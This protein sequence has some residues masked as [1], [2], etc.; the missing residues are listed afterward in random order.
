MA[1]VS[2]ALGVALA[3]AVHL[4]N[5]SALAEFA[6][7]VRSVNGQPDLVLRGAAGGFDEQ[8]YARIA[9]HADVKL[10][11]PAIEVQ[12]YVLDGA[13]QRFAL[14]IIG[15]DP[16]LAAQLAP[17]LMPI[18]A[19]GRAMSPAALFAPDA[20]YLNPAASGR[21]GAAAKTVKAQFGDQLLPLNIAGSIAAEG[22]PMAVMDIADAQ[23][24]FGRLARL[25][26]IDLRLQPGTDQA[27]LLQDLALPAGVRAAKPDEAV[28]RISNL[29]RAY[30]VNLT[31]LALV[32]LFTGTFLVFSVLSLSV[33][34]RLPQLALLG[35]LGLSSGERLQ[36]ILL[37]TLVLG[38]I[39]SAMG[40]A[41]G[42]GLAATALQLLGG[43]L[44][45]GMLG[46]AQPR[47]QFSAWAAL[48]YG[49]LG[50]LA[51]LV[52]GYLPARW[53]QGMAPAQVLKGLGQSDVGDAS[54]HL[55]WLGP[56]LL[57]LGAGL[58]QLPPWHELPLAAYGAVAALLIGGILCVPEGVA[59]LLRLCPRPRHALAL[60]ALE[61][62]R[63]QRHSATVAVA[64]VVVSLSLAVA[65]T[66]MVGSFRGSIMLWL[67]TVLPAELY[68]RT[69]DRSAANDTAFLPPSFI[70]AARRLPG[71]TRVEAQRT[72]PLLLDPQR[73][74]VAL[75]AKPLD[76]KDPR[77]P[78]IGPVLAARPGLP[79]VYVSEAM[80]TLYQARPGSAFKL[81]LRADQ[82][83]VEVWVRGVWR[84]YARQQGSV[85]MDATEFMQLTGDTRSNDIAL[86]LAPGAAMA[87]V[88]AGLRALLPDPS[89]I[90]F[91]SAREIR[92][93]S[94]KIFDRSFA[95]TYWLQAVAIAIGL[96]GIAASHSAQVLARR[97][98]FGL[99]AHLG[100]TK[101]QILTLVAM[102]GAVWTLVGTVLG[103]ALG[104]LVSMVL[105]FVVNPQ[106]FNW[107]ME[108]HVPWP[109]L[110]VLA[111]AVLLAGTVTGVIAGRSAAR[112]DLAQSVKEDW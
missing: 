29:S 36:M 38:L 80:V 68:A 63:D 83:P 70:E 110:G 64:G 5:A 89:L 8:L 62:A 53:A 67:D 48:G 2:I 78:L 111:A 52:G 10:A 107:T 26:S 103:L 18:P 45:S 37:E 43:D 19:A 65:L 47:L 1:I 82:A 56:V 102:E 112:R 49:G 95:V 27:R 85:M 3:F 92:E 109:R 75:I 60:L 50:V 39:G 100:V 42:T 12:T 79:S 90:E 51:A 41:L 25:D 23:L 24:R 40:V 13:G 94:L 69:A 76:A 91:A 98:E 81:P 54:R 57:L 86:W 88:Q 96:F 46:G 44:G 14:R 108:L 104:L 99:L 87:P 77:L 34:Q 7:A 33:A 9:A 35:V 58:A 84:D 97:K 6:S 20:L 21:L 101:G 61:R 72:L 66:V 11:S 28:Q 30:R 22:S 32:A 31:V 71:V 4:I 17:G 15:L 55:S 16:L 74:G 106:S 73:P 93:M 105:V 59:L